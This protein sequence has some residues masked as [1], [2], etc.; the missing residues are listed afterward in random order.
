M[1]N[2]KN[3]FGTLLLGVAV[4]VAIGILVAPDKGSETRKKLLS[5]AQ[6]LADQLNDTVSESAGKINDLKEMAQD[7]MDSLKEQALAYSE[8]TQK[9]MS[10]NINV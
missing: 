2:S 10:N 7:R 8:R 5:G 4:G 6:D 3:I 1:N 9:S